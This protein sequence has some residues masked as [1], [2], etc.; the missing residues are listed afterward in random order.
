MKEKLIWKYYNEMAAV[1]D[2]NREAEWRYLA[3]TVLIFVCVDKHD[4]IWLLIWF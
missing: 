2:Y 1:E 4:D 3:D